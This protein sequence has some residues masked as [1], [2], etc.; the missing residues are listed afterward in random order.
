MM[1]WCV[2]VCV[3]SYS[4]TFFT[5]LDA[6]GLLVL[7]VTTWINLAIFLQMV[8]VELESE[9][10]GWRDIY[11]IYF[12][13]CHPFHTTDWKEQHGTVNHLQQKLTSLITS[14]WIAKAF[15]I[16]FLFTHFPPVQQY[17][18]MKISHPE[19][20]PMTA[21]RIPLVP[22][23]GVWRGAISLKTGGILKMKE[24]KNWF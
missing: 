1:P 5:L 18:K 23:L 16:H 9:R 24:N 17:Y 3:Y 6:T 2:C 12:L 10:Q 21:E 7:F 8:S 4:N 14:M 19:S 22:N 11:S 15:P 13:T 20:L